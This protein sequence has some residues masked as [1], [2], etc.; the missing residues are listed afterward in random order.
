MRGRSEYEAAVREDELNDWKADMA[1]EEAERRKETELYGWGPA[2]DI[3]EMR[4]SY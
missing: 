1:A 3:R 2:D 4:Y